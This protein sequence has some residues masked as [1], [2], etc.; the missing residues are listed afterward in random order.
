VEAFHVH[1]AETGEHT[2]R[3][4]AGVDDIGVHGEVSVVVV[5]V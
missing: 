1:A 3:V 4:Q 2:G 5:D